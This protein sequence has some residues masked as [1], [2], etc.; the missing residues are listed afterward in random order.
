MKKYYEEKCQKTEFPFGE[1]IIEEKIQRPFIRPT[2]PKCARTGE[3]LY[4]DVVGG[5]RDGTIAEAELLAAD[6][7][8]GGGFRSRHFANRL[9][10]IEREEAIVDAELSGRTRNYPYRN[11][12]SIGFDRNIIDREEAVDAIIDRERL[13]NGIGF[14]GGN[15]Y[16]NGFK[17]NIIDREEAREARREGFIH[18]F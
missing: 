17:T 2:R 16:R 8:V 15:Y 18:R 11:Y 6:G 4:D 5:G 3:W 14:V 9:N 10:Q 12:E 1:E 13:N 7:V